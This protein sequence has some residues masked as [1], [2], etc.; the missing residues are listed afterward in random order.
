MARVLKETNA[1]SK[2]EGLRV[3]ARIIARIYVRDTKTKTTTEA[4]K[5]LHK[6]QRN[7]GKTA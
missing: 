4:G 1:G 3:L 2:E 6:E 7:S 5:Q